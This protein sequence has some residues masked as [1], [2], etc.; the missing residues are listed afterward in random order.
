MTISRFL[1]STVSEI[2]LY[3][4]CMQGVWKMWEKMGEGE[5]EHPLTSMCHGFRAYCA[6]ISI[7]GQMFPDGFHGS[8]QGSIL[9]YIF[10]NG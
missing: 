7:W 6:V 10:F 4:S 8:S 3:N 1:N 9:N 2:D 5:A